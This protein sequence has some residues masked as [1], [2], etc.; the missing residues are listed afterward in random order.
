MQLTK[1]DVPAG[2]SFEAADFVNKVNV[3]IIASVC[4]WSLITD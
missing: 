4:S 3:V 1:N 2:W